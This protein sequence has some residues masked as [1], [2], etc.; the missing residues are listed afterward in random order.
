MLFITPLFE[1][2]AARGQLVLLEIHRLSY[3][4][5]TCVTCSYVRPTCAELVVE[6]SE[7][8]AQQQLY[9]DLVASVTREMSGKRLKRHR[10]VRTVGTV[11][12]LVEFGSSKED[13]ATYSVY[14][15]T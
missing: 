2:S 11:T 13:D 8:S 6:M 7:S 12:V 15:G 9:S 3:F 14:Y 10:I 5:H 1:H 4:T